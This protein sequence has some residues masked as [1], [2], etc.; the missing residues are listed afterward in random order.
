MPRVERIEYEDAF[1]HVMN[2]GRERGRVKLFINNKGS[3]RWINIKGWIAIIFVEKL[4]KIK[5]TYMN[6]SPFARAINKL[7]AD[8]LI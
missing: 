1:Y 6:T 4:K 2:R 7:I 3:G 8:S 5:R